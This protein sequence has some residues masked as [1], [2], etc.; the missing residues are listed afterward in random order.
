MNRQCCSDSV[1]SIHAIRYKALK[2][3]ASED[4]ESGVEGG[5]FVVG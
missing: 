5:G 4:V 2:R 1:T 3:D